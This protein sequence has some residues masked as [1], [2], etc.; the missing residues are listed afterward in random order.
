MEGWLKAKGVGKDLPGRRA[1][2]AAA[3]I[4]QMLPGS[5]IPRASMP[6]FLNWH[7]LTARCKDAGKFGFRRRPDTT[8]QVRHPFHSASHESQAPICLAVVWL[9]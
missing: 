7:M 3:V 5:C 4:V 6:A 8:W 9:S 2:V 1:A